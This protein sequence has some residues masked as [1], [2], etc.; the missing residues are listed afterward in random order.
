LVDETE[1]EA[2]AITAVTQNGGGANGPRLTAGGGRQ[3][4]GGRMDGGRT[5]GRTGLT[6]PVPTSYQLPASGYQLPA[7]SSYCCRDRQ[8]P[9]L[10]AQGFGGAAPRPRGSR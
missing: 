10:L 2:F 1:V 8:R 4:G 7:S 3:A 6:R 5:D 9:G